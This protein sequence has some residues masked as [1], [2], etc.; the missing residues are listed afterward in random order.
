MNIDPSRW[1]GLI[2]VLY[3]AF[4]GIMLVAGLWSIYRGLYL[5]G[6]LSIVA[7]LLVLI[8]SSLAFTPRADPN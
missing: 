1:F 8:S 3:H 5:I 4:A 6:A 2:L 7:F